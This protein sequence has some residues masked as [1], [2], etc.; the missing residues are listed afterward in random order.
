MNSFR[1]EQVCSQQKL[2]RYLNTTIQ[3]KIN[4]GFNCIL[5]LLALVLLW[6]NTE[7]G[8]IYTRSRTLWPTNE[9]R[10]FCVKEHN[11]IRRMVGLM[12]VYEN[13]EK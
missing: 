12:F 6:E 4:M 9:D 11:F 2:N 8:N 3:A 7:A 10:D 5:F 1:L 13:S